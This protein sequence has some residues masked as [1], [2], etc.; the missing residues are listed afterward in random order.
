MDEI[1]FVA[2]SELG[3]RFDEEFTVRLGDVDPRGVLRLDGVAR[4]L[5]DVAT[6][7]WQDTGV[8]SDDI[9]V[10]RRTAIRL[11]AGAH[12]PTYLQR[13]RLT[14]WCGGVGAAWAERRTNVYVNDELLVES[15]ALW[16]PTDRSGHPVRMRPSF[17]Q[18]Y[19]E[20]VKDR[21]VS[22]RV[23]IPALDESAT[24]REWPLRRADLDIVG[25]VNNAA[26]WQAVQETA[27]DDVR[28]VSVIH[29]G[30]IEW[31]DDVTLA[32]TPTRAWL[33]VRGETRVSVT[34]VR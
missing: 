4:Y 9:W 20:A 23:T 5:Q 30:S 14:T 34:F 32:S 13:M 15:V 16:V 7:D 19:G 25:H 26:L 24:H 6:D 3:R 11:V 1:E 22:G 21:K 33:L 28:A 2:L 8:D 29:H 27:S 10:V 18:V 12:W 17:F 31:G